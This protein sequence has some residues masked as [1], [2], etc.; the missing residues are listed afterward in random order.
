MARVSISRFGNGGTIPPEGYV[1][2]EVEITAKRLQRKKAVVPS[3]FTWSKNDGPT[4]VEYDRESPK[5]YI[6]NDQSTIDNRGTPIVGG[7]NGE[8]SSLEDF[9]EIFDPTGILSWDD[10]AGHIGSFCSDFPTL[11]THVNAGYCFD[12]S[13]CIRNVFG[14]FGF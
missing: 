7:T 8:T 1:L 6:P 12:I 5:H 11:I 4:T 14:L 3:E 2:P 9:A 10:L 13:F